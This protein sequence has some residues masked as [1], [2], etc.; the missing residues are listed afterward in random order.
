[1]KRE[2]ALR[3]TATLQIRDAPGVPSAL[4]AVVPSRALR[5]GVVNSC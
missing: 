2:H 1:V 4:A 3:F 5:S